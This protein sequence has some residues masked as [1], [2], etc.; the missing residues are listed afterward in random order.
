MA[1]DPLEHDGLP[2]GRSHVPSR[3]PAPLDGCVVTQ[4]RGVILL[5][6][7]ICL[8]RTAARIALAAHRDRDRG[9]IVGA[10]RAE[11]LLNDGRVAATRPGRYRSRPLWKMQEH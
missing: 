7:W 4:F 1:L 8:A 10:D 3:L 6:H 11:F 9:H 5:G 2:V